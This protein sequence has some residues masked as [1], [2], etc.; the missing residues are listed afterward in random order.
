MKVRSEVWGLGLLTSLGLLPLACDK[1]SED[2]G[3]GNDGA[4]ASTSRE[5]NCKFSQ[6]DAESGI[7]RCGIEEI[8]YHRPALGSGCQFT[9]GAPSAS[10]GAASGAEPADEASA[11]AA[12]CDPAD[13]PGKFPYCES[14]EPDSAETCHNGCRV[15]ADCGESQICSCSGSNEPGTCVA[16]DCRTDDDC[17]TG[18]LCASTFDSCGPLEFHCTKPNE[19]CLSGADCDGGICAW[20]TP[21]QEGAEAQAPGRYCEYGVCGRPFLVDARARLADLASREDWRDSTLPEVALEDLTWTER[22]ALAHHYARAAQM[23]HASIAAF[24]RFSLQLLSLGAPPELVEACTNA[25]ADETAH[26][27]ACFEL[28]S[29]YGG[30]AVGPAA[31]PVGGCLDVSSL[32]E[33]IELTIVEGCIGETL[34]ALEATEA[35]EHAN[36]ATVRAALLRIAADE[37]RHVELAFRFVRWAVTSHPSLLAHAE[38]VF[39][40]YTSRGSSAAEPAE[41]TPRLLAHGLLS[42]AQTALLRRAALRDVVVPCAQALLAASARG[43]HEPAILQAS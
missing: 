35:A 32:D 9:F 15:D 23:E 2:D 16:A 7:Q 37:K 10:G 28:A 5:R 17:G 14:D 1:S 40:T 13:C 21:Y 29:R 42:S 38:A 25:I 8:Y 11:G 43:R 4:G 41:T 3:R 31:L 24:A 20:G 39:A 22:Q 33:I 34:A 6:V 26:A 12:A 18:E 36:D 30:T 19:V 27:R